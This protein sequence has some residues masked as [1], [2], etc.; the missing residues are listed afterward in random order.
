MLLPKS[1]LPGREFGIHHDFI[2]IIGSIHLLP[3]FVMIV[4]GKSHSQL[5]CRMRG[6]QVFLIN[7]K[8]AK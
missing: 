6:I 8:L 7:T 5:A 2:F 3:I 1:H 4:S